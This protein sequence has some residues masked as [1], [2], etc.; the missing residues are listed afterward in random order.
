MCENEYIVI[1]LLGTF[2]HT[3][4]LNR[5]IVCATSLYLI[6]KLMNVLLISC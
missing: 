3:H 6:M 4:A 1:Q 5:V 2:K